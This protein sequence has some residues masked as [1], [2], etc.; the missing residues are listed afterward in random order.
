M[1]FLS[2]ASVGTV[3]A[4]QQ[5]SIEKIDDDMRFILLVFRRLQLF[6][7]ST[8]CAAKPCQQEYR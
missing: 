8:W 6:N 1:L 5:Y 7:S 2:L 4:S 3:L